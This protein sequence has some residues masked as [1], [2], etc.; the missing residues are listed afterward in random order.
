RVIR[1]LL[2]SRCLFSH[3]ALF[4]LNRQDACSTRKSTLC[5][6]G[7][8]P[9]QKRIMTMVQD[10]SIET[11]RVIGTLTPRLRCK[12]NPVQLNVMELGAIP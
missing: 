11:M 7:I 9:V 6:T 1:H 5:G 10:L 2:K 12:L 4:W 8:L 3:L